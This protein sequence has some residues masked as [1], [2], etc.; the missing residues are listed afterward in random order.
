[1]PAMLVFG[2]KS[3]QRWLFAPGSSTSM[4][5]QSSPLP[6]PP[7][8]RR[9]PLGESV[10]GSLCSHL[11]ISHLIPNHLHSLPSPLTLIA[12]SL[13][14]LLLHP[15]PT[16]LLSV[17]LC[18]SRIIRIRSCRHMKQVTKSSKKYNLHRWR[19]FFRALGKERKTPLSQDCIPLQT[20][21]MEFR[22]SNTGF[23]AWVHH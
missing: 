21:L 7:L 19:Y 15:L 12:S 14:P 6:A 8:I 22:R 1:M 23:L 17:S 9:T 5:L 4:T 10:S 20:I 16:Y 13:A 2:T 11:L 18:P 3:S